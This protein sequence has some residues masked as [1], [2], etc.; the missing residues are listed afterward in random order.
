MMFLDQFK[1]FM[2]LVFIAVA[3][4][5]GITGV[6]SDTI[7]IVVIVV[8]NRVF[9]AHPLSFREQMIAFALSS[10]V[11]FVVEAEKLI[12]RMQSKK[13]VPVVVPS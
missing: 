3:V 2:M 7:A 8:L 6:T 13:A 5:S 11:F 1:D 4:I 10:I 9:K 12:R